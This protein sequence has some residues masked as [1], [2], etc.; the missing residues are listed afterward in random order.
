MAQANLLI[1][2]WGDALLIAAYVLNKVPPKS[3]PL[4]PYELWTGRKPDLSNHR[5]RGCAAFVHDCMSQYGK[6][7]PRGKKYIFI[8]YRDLSKGYVLIG[9]Q[10][11]KRVTEIESR[12]I[13]FM[14]KEFPN[15]G[16]IR[17]ADQLYEIEEDH[18]LSDPSG[19]GLTKSADLGRCL[20]V[21]DHMNLDKGILSIK[22]SP[23]RE[24][25]KS[26]RK[27]VPKR[28]Y[29]IEGHSLFVSPEN[30][31]IS[32]VDEEKPRNVHEALSCPA[33]RLWKKAME[34]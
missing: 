33:K 1:S 24:S 11:D 29:D 3:I 34:E 28:H 13:I 4:T 22:D 14:E 27:H 9:D 25:R 12:N 15:K 16:G 21:E 17:N 31:D 23:P 6:L 7:G 19:S 10:G 26:S 5:T 32:L 8:R 20:P 18:T 2:L 30:G